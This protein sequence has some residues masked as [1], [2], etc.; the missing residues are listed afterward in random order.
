[1]PCGLL[2]SDVRYCSH[3]VRSVMHLAHSCIC[4]VQ[5]YSSETTQYTAQTKQG[6]NSILNVS[7]RRRFTCS[8][9]S[10]W[11]G[12]TCEP[13][14]NFSPPSFGCQAATGAAS[15]PAACQ[16][17]SSWPLPRYAC[18]ARCLCPGRHYPPCPFMS[19]DQHAWSCDNLLPC[20]VAAHVCTCAAIH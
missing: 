9:W 2:R 12:W 8:A 10:C 7:N 19:C 11:C 17:H 4:N 13:P 6:C 5:Q 14:T 18:M 16:A 15:W 20:L 3:I 1:M